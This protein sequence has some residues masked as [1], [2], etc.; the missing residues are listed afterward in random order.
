M[1]SV[2]VAHKVA[3]VLFKAYR[4]VFAESYRQ[5]EREVYRFVQLVVSLNTE[6]LMGNPAL[7]LSVLAMSV[8]S[9]RKTCPAVA[10]LNH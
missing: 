9:L 4:S 10:T 3:A 7:F 5:L 8:D 2:R 1:T 6:A